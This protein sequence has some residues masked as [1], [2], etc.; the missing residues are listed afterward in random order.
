MLKTISIKQSFLFSQTNDNNKYRNPKMEEFLPRIRLRRGYGTTGYADPPTSMLPA[1][2]PQARDYG[3]TGGATGG[4]DGWGGK[5]V[6]QTT[7]EREWT[8]I[9]FMPTPFRHSC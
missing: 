3:V 1:F 6:L 9:Q 5:E 4:T 2:V 7:N 8:R